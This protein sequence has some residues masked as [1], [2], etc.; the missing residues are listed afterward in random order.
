[1]L[2][3]LIKSEKKLSW[4]GRILTKQTSSFQS[5]SEK[6]FKKFNQTKTEETTTFTTRTLIY[7]N[8][9]FIDFQ[10]QFLFYTNESEMLMIFLDHL[11]QNC[12]D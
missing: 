7:Q 9:I 6:F 8:K 10:M 4:I 11:E 1:M 2:K 12:K 5:K 3:L